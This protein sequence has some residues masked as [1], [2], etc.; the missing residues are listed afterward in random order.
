LDTPEKWISRNRNPNTPEKYGENFMPETKLPRQESMDRTVLAVISGLGA[1]QFYQA[2]SR[3]CSKVAL[4]CDD[5]TDHAKAIRNGWIT[6]SSAAD[7]NAQMAERI[8]MG[9]PF[10]LTED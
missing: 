10:V 4:K 3:V 7:A 9:S 2:L 8:G 6:L 1:V 5:N